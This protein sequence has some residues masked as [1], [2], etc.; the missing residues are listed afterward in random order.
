M[1]TY[2][3][4]LKEGLVSKNDNCNLLDGT[5][6]GCWALQN[7]DLAQGHILSVSYENAVDMLPKLIIDAFI[8]KYERIPDTSDL[9]DI[10]QKVS[11]SM[12]IAIEKGKLP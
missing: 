9:I 11:E 1:S 8:N 5:P 7:S 6:D 12:K 4:L 3:S 10:Q 2:K